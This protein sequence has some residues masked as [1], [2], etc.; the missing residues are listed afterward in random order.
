MK[1]TQSL[2]VVDDIV[3]YIII[4]G[5]LLIRANLVLVMLI[6]NKYGVRGIIFLTGVVF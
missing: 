5:S 3:E 4:H 6:P 2:N 1:S